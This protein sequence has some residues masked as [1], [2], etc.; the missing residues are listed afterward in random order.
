MKTLKPIEIT[1]GCGRKVCIG[2][3][4]RNYA[5]GPLTR[6]R[7][8]LMANSVLGKRAKNI[9]LFFPTLPFQG[10]RFKAGLT[11]TN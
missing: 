11:G 9:N 6:F 5:K 10:P 1:T 4:P 8:L 7:Y 2:K 3:G